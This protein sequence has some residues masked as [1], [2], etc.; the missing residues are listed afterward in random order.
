[1]PDLDAHTLRY[2]VPPEDAFWRWSSDGDAVEWAD[3]TTIAF[4]PE[5][6][7]VL[8][9]LAAHG[10]P[11]FDLVLLV[12]AACRDSWRDDTAQLGLL[13][14]VLSLRARIGAIQWI[15]EAISALDRVHK[16]PPDLRTSTTG[17]AE[18][19]ALVFEAHPLRSSPEEAAAAVSLLSTGL[20]GEMLASADR[21]IK[22]VGEW[23]RELRGLLDGLQRV[24]EERVRLW[25]ITGLE[26]VVP[27]PV[28]KSDR[29]ARPAQ[30]PAKPPPTIHELLRE[31]ERD[32][33]LRSLAQLTRDLMAVVHLPRPIAD[34]EE[35]PLGGVSDITNRGPLDRLLLSELAHDNETLTLRV[36]LRE[37]MYLRR[38]RPPSNPPRQRVILLDSGLRMWGVPRVYAAA[39]ALSLAATAGRRTET[40]AFRAKGGSVVPVDLTTRAG[41]VAHLAA[42]DPHAHPGDALPEFVRQLAEVGRRPAGGATQAEAWTP[43]CTPTDVVLITGEDVL[44]DP[45]FRRRLAESDL[46]SFYIASVSRDGRFRLASRT[47]RGTKTVREA[48]LKLDDLFTAESSPEQPPAA[49]LIDPGVDPQL[50]AI[51]RLTQFPLRLPHGVQ[52]DGTFRVRGRWAEDAVVSLTN[53]RRL[54][55]WDESGC[56]ARQLTDRVPPG[57]LLWWN[58]AGKDLNLKCVVG[59]ADFTALHVVDVDLVTK[60]VT[61]SPLET[62]QRG[63]KAVCAHGGAL[64]VVRRTEVEVFDPADGHRIH[65]LR[66]RRDVVWVRDRFF[67][68]SGGWYALSF[69]GVAA[70]LEG[71][72]PRD[73]VAPE[74]VAVMFDSAAFDA[75][76]AV[77]TDA[78]LVHS[79]LDFRR[80]IP[81]GLATPVSVTAISKDGAQLVVSRWQHTHEKHCLVRLPGLETE[82]Q[83]GFPKWLVEGSDWPTCLPR[84]PLRTR[85]RGVIGHRTHLVLVTKSGAYLALTRDPNHDRLLLRPTPLR[86]DALTRE[87]HFRARRRRPGCGYFLRD[88]VWADGSRA[89]LDSRGLLH[90]KSSESAIPEATLVLYDDDVAGWCSTGQT[91]GATYFLGSQGHSSSLD[92]I[93]ETAVN[94]FLGRLK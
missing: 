70:H 9:P 75:P 71:V 76:L 32:E 64:F 59:H 62:D 53:D 22:S 21:P 89:V 47:A 41:L 68:A 80:P 6:L 83:Y 63:G 11:S 19:A 36:A 92:S 78:T 10:L 52:W 45:D 90:L 86:T 69:T 55:L 73:R 38:E 65:V 81:H 42:L 82:L 72:L 20:T 60:R 48:E 23:I 8:Q 37:A 1:M 16:L 79:A 54:M 66:L 51:L 74:S 28:R 25:T 27:P 43:T 34:R 94:P 2:F 84:R 29:P 77:T 49:P 24:D 67:R 7:A 57:R 33:Q 58:V 91:W 46:T 87:A 18:L 61:I 15:Q 44:A 12:L 14:G 39:V 13:T 3:G 17:K 5:L 26:Q 56:G 85:F 4:R 35:L 88:A 50:P 30:P 93:L 40:R 31:L